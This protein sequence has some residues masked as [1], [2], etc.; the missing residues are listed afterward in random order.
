MSCEFVHLPGGSGTTGIFFHKGS[1]G[2]CH[3]GD[4]AYESNDWVVISSRAMLIIS[5]LAGFW[6]VLMAALS[7]L[8]CGF[9]C[10]SCLEGTAL[11]VAW[12][13]AGI[14]FMFY[15]QEDCGVNTNLTEID[16]DNF[17]TRC[18]YNKSSTFMIVACICYLIAMFLQCW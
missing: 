14:T 12:S 3:N 1:D 7:L 16:E 13:T 2:R 11:F 4:A 6:T 5:I 15:G 8:K 18:T 10:R 17:E 9:Y